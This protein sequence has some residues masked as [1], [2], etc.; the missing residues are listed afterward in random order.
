M[1]KIVNVYIIYDLDTWPRNPANNFKF[2]DCLFEAT[3]VVKNSDKEKD[4]YSGYG[5]TFDRA[6]SWSFDNDIAESVIVF[7]VDNNSSSHANN[8]RITF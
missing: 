4:V 2:K 6:D 3:S 8:R 5:M 1:S 7:G